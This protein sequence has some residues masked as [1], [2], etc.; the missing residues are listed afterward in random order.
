MDTLKSID[1]MNVLIEINYDRIEGYRAAAA[2]TDD[3]DLKTLFL[4]LA[5]RSGECRIKLANEVISA[6]GTPSE[7]T[8]SNGKFLRAWKTVK[9]AVTNKDRKAIFN[10]VEFGEEAID[11]IYNNALISY[12]DDINEEQCNLLTG[13][14]SLIKA[15]NERTKKLNTEL[16][17]A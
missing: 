11:D 7:Q 6:G 10:S 15:N 13:Q 17:L 16:L 3:E 2:E 8:G 9:L 14:H 1:E 12:S 5:D 4:Q